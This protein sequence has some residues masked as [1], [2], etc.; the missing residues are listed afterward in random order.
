[1]VKAKDTVFVLRGM[2]PLELLGQYRLSRFWFYKE[3]FIFA[4]KK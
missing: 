1:M 4:R 3:K 2:L